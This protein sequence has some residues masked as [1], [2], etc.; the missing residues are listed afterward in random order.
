M[1]KSPSDGTQKYYATLTYD[2]MISTD[3]IVKRIV[4][5]SSLSEGDIRSCIVEFFNTITEELLE[6]HSVKLDGLGVFS[7]T[8]NSRPAETAD[9]VT[10]DNIKKIRVQFRPASKW[11]KNI[12]G[13]ATFE[14]VLQ[15]QSKNKATKKNSTSTTNG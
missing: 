9:K 5:R 14:K 3:T 8:M 11:N 1:R 7:L 6:N 13:N 15:S 4:D 10:A 12:V 2:G